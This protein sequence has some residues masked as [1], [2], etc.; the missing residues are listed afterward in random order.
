[1]L[2]LYRYT[3]V[4]VGIDMEFDTWFPFYLR[5]WYGP[6]WD[7]HVES[8]IGVGREKLKDDMLVIRYEDCCANP[9]DT[10]GKVCDFLGVAY[11]PGDA[12]RAVELSSIGNMK[13]WERKYVGEIN[14]ENASFYRG[15]MRNDEWASLLSEEQRSEFMRV[16]GEALH[17]DRKSTRLNSS[18][19]DISR[20]PSSA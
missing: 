7:Q 3:T 1:M 2:S 11:T 19:T 10:L 12:Q 18:H 9:H 5:G 8:W 17:L 4:R 15:K 14:D 20:M 6:R 13:K 16:S